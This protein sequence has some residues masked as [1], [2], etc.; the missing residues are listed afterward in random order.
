[1]TLSTRPRRAASWINEE[2]VA[3]FLA[4]CE[5]FLTRNRPDVVW[6]YGGDPVSI[7]LQQ[8]VKRLDIPILFA[9]HNFA[10][11]DPEAF[12]M[13]DYVIVPT[14]FLPAI[15]L[16]HDRPGQL[17]VAAGR[18]GGAGSLNLTCVGEGHAHLKSQIA[19]SM[20]AL[21]RPPDGRGAN[22]LMTRAI[23]GDSNTR[24][25]KTQVTAAVRD[26]VNPS[27][28]RAFHVFRAGL[29]RFFPGGGQ[30]SLAPGGGA[31][32]ASFL[33]ELGIDLSRIKN[34]TIMPNAPD[35]GSSTP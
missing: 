19:K 20:A 15:L 35:R 28:G 10:Y 21:T 3:A 5:I 17:E 9:L 22:I 12:R 4:R 24:E 31:G 6:T 16:G 29:R 30:N 7:V 2:E 18:G 26:F 25:R 1:M 11:R 32:K 33:R 27:R 34:V 8:L 13:A 14:E 23:V